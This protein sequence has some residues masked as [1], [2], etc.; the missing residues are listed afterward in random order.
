[1]CCM[2]DVELES[3]RYEK[4]QGQSGWVQIT[5]QYDFDRGKSYS[6]LF[7]WVIS[8]VWGQY[9]MTLNYRWTAAQC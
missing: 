3:R 9:I 1:M 4:E 2:I 8:D 5:G 6:W 7:K